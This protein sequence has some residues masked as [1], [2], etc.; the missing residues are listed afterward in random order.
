MSHNAARITAGALKADGTTR[1]A[2]SDIIGSPNSG[3]LAI[4][5]GTAWTAAP[6][7]SGEALGY[8][9]VQPAFFNYAWPVSTSGSFYNTTG[10]RL[11][12][13]WYKGAGVLKRSTI[14]DLDAS[15]ATQS[16]STVYGDQWTSTLR[17]T[18]AGVWLIIANFNYAPNAL[19]ASSDF[20]LQG[21]GGIAGPKILIGGGVGRRTATYC[22]VFE[23]TSAATDVYLTLIARPGNVRWVTPGALPVLTV[24][25]TKLG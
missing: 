12:K 8:S 13:T 4:Y 24:Q 15:G 21:G 25:I 19:S 14:A 2:L 9:V 7:P 18:E 17:F 16:I 1:P 10:S 11:R 23:T 5:T 22:H 20:Q 6:A 3:E